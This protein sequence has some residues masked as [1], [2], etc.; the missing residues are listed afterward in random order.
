MMLSPRCNKVK[1]NNINDFLELVFLHIGDKS[2]HIIVG[3]VG[4]TSIVHV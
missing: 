1:V 4:N 2:T 3:L